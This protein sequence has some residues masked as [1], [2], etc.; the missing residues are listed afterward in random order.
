MTL[1]RSVRRL[2]SFPSRD[3]ALAVP[4]LRRENAS[5]GW[6]CQVPVFLLRYQQLRSVARFPDAGGHEYGVDCGMNSFVEGEQLAYPLIIGRRALGVR[7]LLKVHSFIPSQW[8]IVGFASIASLN[9]C[10]GA[11]PERYKTLIQASEPLSMTSR[12][13]TLP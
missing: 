6:L 9:V 10:Y 7:F 5:R 13:P 12:V 2:G 8:T 1:C 4:D 3:P 11:A